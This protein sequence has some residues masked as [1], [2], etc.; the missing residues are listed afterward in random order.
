MANLK[1]L[2]GTDYIKCV[3]KLKGMEP[4]SRPKLDKK[5]AVRLLEILE[6]ASPIRAPV[7]QSHAE[8]SIVRR[9]QKPMPPKT[10]FSTSLS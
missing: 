8:V 7:R 2:H 10:E 6:K 1:L 4:D 3:T 5:S 9:K